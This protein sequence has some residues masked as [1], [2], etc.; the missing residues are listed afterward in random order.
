MST[1]LS[2]TTWSEL[3]IKYADTLHIPLKRG[4]S[5]SS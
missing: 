5:L 2:I 3:F 1:D 4:Q